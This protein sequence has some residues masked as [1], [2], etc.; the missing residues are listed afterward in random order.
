MSNLLIETSPTPRKD[1]VR[2]LRSQGHRVLLAQDSAE[3]LTLLQE[4]SIE[5]VVISLT[6]GHTPAAEFAT[7]AKTLQPR[8][9]ILVIAEH[10]GSD[11]Q[12]SFADAV[13]WQPVS[14]R[15]MNMAVSL[16]LKTPSG[17]VLNRK[18]NRY[19]RLCGGKFSREL[20]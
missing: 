13:V 6:E 9:R 18:P 10:P 19:L 20:N 4:V 17:I 7:A 2:M 16:L 12:I 14:L 15:A 8:L 1:I 3:A 5:I 11:P